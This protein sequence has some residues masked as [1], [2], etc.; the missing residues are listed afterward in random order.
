MDNWIAVSW[1]MGRMASSAEQ[2]NRVRI[3]DG[4]AAVSAQV[5][6]FGESRSLDEIREGRGQ[7]RGPQPHRHK[8]EDLR[9]G[10]SPALCVYTERVCHGKTAVAP[11]FG[12]TAILYFRRFIMSNKKIW[13]AVIAL[14]AV[15]AL[16]AGIWFAT[17]PQAVEGAKT[18]TVA[19]VHSDGNE[20]VF[21]YHTDA[22]YLGE[23]LYAEGLI[24]AEGVDEGMFNIVDGE[25]ADWNE[26]KSYWSLYQG[27]EYAMQG[28]DTTPIKDGDSFKLVYTLG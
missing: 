11:I 9:D 20:K 22:E 6:S 17:R 18:I 26:N 1:R 8:S 27:E 13:I 2:D 10:V 14:V 15:V 25:K 3:P 16:M 4:T 21:T 7:R 28:V 23:V 5:P 24:K 12:A 19:V